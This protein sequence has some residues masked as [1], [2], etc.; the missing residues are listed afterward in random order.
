MWCSGG[1]HGFEHLGRNAAD[2]R[3]GRHIFANHG[4]GGDDG[5]FAYRYARQDGGARSYPGVLFDGNGRQNHAA[6]F[7][8]VFGMIHGKDIHTRGDEYIVF[9]RD[10][11]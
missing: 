3:I 8:G 11:A 2:Y 6:S 9:Q 4:T 10:A 7:G 5:V 1:F